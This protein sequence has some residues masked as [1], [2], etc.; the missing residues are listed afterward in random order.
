MKIINLTLNN[1]KNIWYV[2]ALRDGD[3]IEKTSHYLQVETYTW[4][5]LTG[6][7]ARLCFQNSIKLF[8]LSQIK[9]EITMSKENAIKFF[10]LSIENPELL[11]EAKKHSDAENFC[12]AL[13]KVAKEKGFE[14]SAKELEETMNVLSKLDSSEISEDDLESV[15]GGSWLSDAWKKCKSLYDQYGDRVK[16]TF[17]A[18]K[19]AWNNFGK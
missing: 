12:D 7:L 10:K 19:D 15:A 11:E 4:Q 14:C 18:A 3:D 1:N 13:S 2:F 6:Q 9:E 16:K 8:S 5:N 17:N